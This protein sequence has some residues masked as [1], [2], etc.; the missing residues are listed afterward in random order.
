MG[1][2]GSGGHNRKSAAQKKAEGNRGRRTIN[3]RE[4]KSAPATPRDAPPTL[5]PLEQ[6]FWN[7]IFPVVSEMRVMQQ[8]DVLA[9]GQLCRF[10]A[11]ERECSLQLGKM[12]RL[13]PKKNEKGEVVGASL[14][15][16][17]RLRSDAARHVRA[18]LAVFGLGPSFRAAL[19]V[20]QPA[21]DNPQDPLENIRRAKTAS[22]VVQ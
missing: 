9:L 18:Y 15:P 13:I 20:E 10:L 3:E 21:G 7:Q 8:S 12:G 16:I 5:T 17:A 2:K 19:Q 14:N 1:G 11:E 22:D 6:E 4:P